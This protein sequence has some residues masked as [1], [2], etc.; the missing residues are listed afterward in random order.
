[1]T[2]ENHSWH[3]GSPPPEIR[4]HSIAKHRVL[5]Q[6]LEKYVRVLTSNKRIPEMRLTLIDGFAGG[7]IYRR[8]DN[9]EQHRGS[10]FV[11]FEAMKNANTDIQEGRIK[12]F[13]LEVE[14]FFVEKDREAFEYLKHAVKNSEFA[15]EATKNAH[16]LNETFAD[17]CSRIEERIE[18]RARGGRAIFVLDQFGYSD[19]PLPLIRSI[20]RRLPNAE[21]LLTFA[22]DSLIDYLSNSEQ[23]MKNLDR[24]GISLPTNELSAIKAQQDWRRAIQF[25]LHQE[26]KDKTEAKFYT[27]FFIRSQDAHRDFWL[28]HLSGHARARDVMVQLHWK[29]NRSFAH[30]GKAGLNML[31]YD[32][33]LDAEVT[34]QRMLPGFF[35][36][37]TARAASQSLL[38]EQLPRLICDL[39][40]RIPYSALFSRITNETPASSEII[41]SVIADL[42][43]EG[44]LE[45]RDKT[46]TIQRESRIQSP[47]D[48]IIRSPQKLLFQG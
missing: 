40:D 28:I 35:F 48:L 45:I 19:V 36:D 14:Y 7:G 33:N 13:Q 23:T 10:P 6:Y 38:L 22:T 29:E 31:G 5:R 42:R 11:L 24:V 3:L 18:T 21:V 34:G 41:K 20:L 46:G 39:P 32:E 25:L 16:F 43:A 9:G 1:M 27:P 37:E 17:C 4:P 47:S 44:V 30:Y 12:P 2:H 8:S 26:I 15:A